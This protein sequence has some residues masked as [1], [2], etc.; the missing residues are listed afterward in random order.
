MLGTVVGPGVKQQN[1]SLTAGMVCNAVGRK[2][3]TKQ[4]GKMSKMRGDE[5]SLNKVSEG[6]SEKMT[7]KTDE[8]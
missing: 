7:V 4:I 2:M 5:C 8:G 1:K 3:L 6:H